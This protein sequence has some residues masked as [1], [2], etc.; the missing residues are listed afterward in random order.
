M[1]TKKLSKIRPVGLNMMML[2]TM[3]LKSTEEDIEIPAI[4]SVLPILLFAMHQAFAHLQLQLSAPAE[5]AMQRHTTN[6][7]KHGTSIATSNKISAF[8][9]A[10]AAEAMESKTD[11][12]DDKNK[13]RQIKKDAF[14]SAL[15]S[16]Q[17]VKHNTT[18]SLDYLSRRSESR[19]NRSSRMGVEKDDNSFSNSMST[20]VESSSSHVSTDEASYSQSSMLDS[21]INENEAIADYSTTSTMSM[22]FALEVKEEQIRRQSMEM[23]RLLKRKIKLDYEL[24]KYNYQQQQQQQMET[25][26]R[27]QQAIKR[28]RKIKIQSDPT[29]CNVAN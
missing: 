14:F 17:V 1:S 21:V 2:K 27:T 9:T 4:E 7:S 16:R 25:T 13:M 28:W 10:A 24:S 29:D 5:K 23:K 18:S 22:P 3:V 8:Y 26:P 20:L 12:D 11:G 15:S 6:K 19:S